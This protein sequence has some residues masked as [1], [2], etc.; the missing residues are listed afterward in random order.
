MGSNF[1]ELS[2]LDGEVIHFDSFNYCDLLL[3]NHCVSINCRKSFQFTPWQQPKLTW[4]IQTSDVLS[5]SL[6]ARELRDV[7]RAERM[8]AFHS[9]SFT[10]Q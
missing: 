1:A 5:A 3:L 4:L 6:L 8:K 2:A 7:E 10:P 9:R